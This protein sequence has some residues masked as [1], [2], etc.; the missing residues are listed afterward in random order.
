MDSRRLEPIMQCYNPIQH[1]L[2]PELRSALGPLTAKLK[3][4]SH[5]QG[6]SIEELV[7]SP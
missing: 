1:E 3:L 7:H 5:L 4:I 2:L 6:V